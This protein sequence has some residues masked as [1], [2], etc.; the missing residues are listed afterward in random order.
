MIRADDFE[1]TG[2][3]IRIADAE[4]R[5]TFPWN[6]E[7]NC[8]VHENWNIVH[9]GMLIP[10]CHQIYICP[11]NCLRGVIMTADEM[12]ARDRISAVMPDEEE[13]YDGRLEQVTIDGVIDVVKKLPVRPRAIQVF[14]VCTHLISGCDVRFIFDSIKKA[15]P[16]I[17]VMEC[18]M[19]PIRQKLTVTPEMRQRYEMMKVLSLSGSTGRK[20]K[21]VS[22]L[23]DD[24]PVKASV[25]VL[26][27][28][29][30]MKESD[31][32]AL[33]EKCGIDLI[34]VKKA[35]TFDEYLEMGASPV[36]ITRSAFSA[37]GIN[38][39]AEKA[40]VKGLYLP[41]A[42]SYDEIDRELTEYLTCIFER[43]A[44][45]V[46]G[47]SGQNAQYPDF[48][49]EKNENGGNNSCRENN[50]GKAAENMVASW[51][52][53]QRKLTEEAVLHTRD[54]VGEKPI[55]IDNLCINRP[56]GFARFLF[57]H[58][59]NVKMIVADSISSE[60]ADD[61]RILKDE[62]PDIYVLNPAGAGSGFDRRYMSIFIDGDREFREPL[63]VGPKA[64]YFTGT[65]HF[66]NAVEYDGGDGYM[67]IRHIL[68]LINDA[69]RIE[70]NKEIVTGKGLG[71][72]GIW[73][74]GSV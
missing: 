56:V 48:P 19:D 42:V 63:A 64:A 57:E 12:G 23:G 29:L 10:E 49:F 16:D 15:L 31:I 36:W 65:S 32:R 24:L 7:Y 26:G 13:L 71:L 1:K 67:G 69:V 6:L 28:D 74:G 20:N 52:E 70:N 9:T 62:C 66:V 58:G 45:G 39:A 55:V 40:G 8:P 44:P 35:V 11:E 3:I 50:A 59:F 68:A 4:C 51:S 73:T 25:S 22:V 72:N 38:K 46:H 17:Y 34:E 60:E 33:T 37:Y 53:E 18:F 47:I 27:D 14:L 54:A 43:I 21:T 61:L 2:N 30:P 41:A 5:R